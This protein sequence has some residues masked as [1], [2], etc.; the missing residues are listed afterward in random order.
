MGRHQGMDRPG[1]RQVPEGSGE[2]GKMEETR[3]EIICSAPRTL[4][5]K[6]KIRSKMIVSPLPLQKQLGIKTGTN[7]PTCT[8]CPDCSPGVSCAMLVGGGGRV[9]H[10]L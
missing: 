6:G 2:Q 9:G 1:V 7:K 10:H 3:S 4:A 8:I 5:D